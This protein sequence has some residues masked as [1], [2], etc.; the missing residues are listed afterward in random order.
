M[1]IKKVKEKIKKEIDIL[2][3]NENFLESFQDEIK[4][5]ID[6]KISIKKQIEI[7]QKSIKDK[8]ISKKSY[9]DFVKKLKA[10]NRQEVNN[11]NAYI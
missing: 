8:K 6:K 11:D 5:M 4:L 10:G 9:I 2:T 7:L 3:S 1:N